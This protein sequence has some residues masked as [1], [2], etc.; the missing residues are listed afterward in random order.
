MKWD[1]FCLEKKTT[2]FSIPCRLSFFSQ[3]FI[4]IGFS[5]EPGQTAQMWTLAWLYTGGK[6]FKSLLVSAG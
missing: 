2:N 5:T 1:I 4:C 6:D 3:C